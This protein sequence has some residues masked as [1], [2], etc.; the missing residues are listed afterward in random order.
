[1]DILICQQKLS[2]ILGI[3]NLAQSYMV[4]YDRLKFSVWDQ[5]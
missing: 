2:L 4:I 3:K 1:M 5:H